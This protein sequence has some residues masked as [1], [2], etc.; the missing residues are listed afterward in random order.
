MNAL[1]MYDHQTDTL[2]SQFLSRG[3]KGPLS[4]S[5]LEIVPA[6][7]TTWGQWSELHPDTRVLEKRGRYFTDQYDGYYASN[8]AG[9]LGESNSDDRL[10]KKDLVVGISQGNSAKA[11][12]F[13]VISGEE[14]VNDYFA[15]RNVVVAFAP[16]SETGVI[17]DRSVDNRTLS[18]EPLPPEKALSIMRDRETGTVWE[19]AHRARRRGAIVLHC[20]GAAAL[21]LRFLVRLERLSPRH[22]AVWGRVRKRE[23]TPARYPH[24]RFH[25][26]QVFRSDQTPP[27]PP[28]NW[29]EGPW[30][31]T[32][33]APVRRPRS[34]QCR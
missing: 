14:V 29:P 12:P 17:F 15:G 18:F 13:R 24:D 1:V 16:E 19:P 2:W 21:P 6:L 27:R 11:Y 32:R 5:Q 25:F 34:W 22:G 9:K 10:S 31:R 8:M 7:Q 4:G 26:H 28:W 20:P 23:L 3:V 30:G 33:S